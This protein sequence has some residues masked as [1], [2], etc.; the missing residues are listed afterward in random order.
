MR[1]VLR[2]SLKP[3]SL[4]RASL[5]PV[6]LQ[7]KMTAFSSSSARARY[8][9]QR[10][11]LNTQGCSSPKYQLGRNFISSCACTCTSSSCHSSAHTRLTIFVL[12]SS[13]VSHADGQ[14]FFRGTKV[15][16]RNLVLLSA[17]KVS[18]M[19]PT[20]TVPSKLTRVCVLRASCF[21]IS[22]I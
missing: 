11:H 13:E 15:A 5:P 14:T 4:P 10:K 17:G 20:S 21:A 2:H 12:L 7:A 19:I 3:P 18:S 9:P 6:S 22:H 8:T 16:V 1:F